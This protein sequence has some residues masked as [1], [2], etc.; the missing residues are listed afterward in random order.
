MKIGLTNFY[1][2]DQLFF[3][4]GA[5]LKMKPK[6]VEHLLTDNMLEAQLDILT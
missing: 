1:E 3:S 6:V 5:V 2:P 4:S